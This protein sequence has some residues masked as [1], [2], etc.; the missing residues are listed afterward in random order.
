M[1]NIAFKEF[2]KLEKNQNFR[3]EFLYFILLVNSF[4]DAIFWDCFY[5]GTSKSYKKR[6][7]QLYDHARNVLDIKRPAEAKLISLIIPEEKLKIGLHETIDCFSLPF[8]EK[9]IGQLPPNLIE[10]MEKDLRSNHAIFMRV[11]D[12]LGRKENITIQKALNA[13]RIKRNLLLHYDDKNIKRQSVENDEIVIH[14]LGMFLLPKLMHAF[15]GRVRHYEKKQL[16][17]KD[18]SSKLLEMHNEIQMTQKANYQRVTAL[19]NSKDNLKD[20]SRRKKRIDTSIPWRAYHLQHKIRDG[21]KTDYRE[22]N[23]RIHYHFIGRKNIDLIEK[24]LNLESAVN[25]HF[26]R[27]IEDF[28]LLSHEV[29]KWLHVAFMAMKRNEYD[30]I[31]GRNDDETK[32][33]KAIRNEIAHNGFFWNCK[34][35]N[36]DLIAVSMVFSYILS[37]HCFFTNRSETQMIIDNL[38]AIFKGEKYKILDAIIPQP[39]TLHIREWSPKNLDKLSKKHDAPI[40][41]RLNFGKIVGKWV[42]ALQKSV[43]DLNKKSS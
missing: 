29:N 33:I 26:K 12:D 20:K 9:I 10:A 21:N 28:Y 19:E 8:S 15:V 34:D 25:F 36:G 39:T 43:I 35:E 27:D 5:Y 31:I 24:Y 40:K 41:R 30:K 38:N 42:K 32:I 14:A 6:R 18:L 2:A 23:F 7:A 22:N 17:N 13:L 11:I 4:I 37:A 1:S 16:K 3:A